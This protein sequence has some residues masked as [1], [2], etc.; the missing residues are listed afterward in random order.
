[1]TEPS[2]AVARIPEGVR[3]L[4]QRPRLGALYKGDF[5]TANWVF[6]NDFGGWHPESLGGCGVLER[7]RPKLKARPQSI[8]A[9]QL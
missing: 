3:S 7:E 1:M 5:S 8:G 6:A 9:A 2:K 4:G